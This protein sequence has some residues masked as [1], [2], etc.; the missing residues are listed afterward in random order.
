MHALRECQRFTTLRALCK[1]LIEPLLQAA[2]DW[3]LD[4]PAPASAPSAGAAVAPAGYHRSALSGQICSPPVLALECVL[5]GYQ[6]SSELA[7]GALPALMHVLDAAGEHDKRAVVHVLR[8]LMLVFSG[9]DAVWEVVRA[10]LQDFAPTPRTQLMHSLYQAQWLVGAPLPVPA[11][12]AS[13]TP[14][15]SAAP[16]AQVQ[17]PAPAA[18]AAAP[19]AAAGP[20]P[21]PAA[22]AAAGSEV[23]PPLPNPTVG[24]V[25]GEWAS[26]AAGGHIKWALSAGSHSITGAGAAAAGG[27]AGSVVRGS[28]RRVHGKARAGVPSA[29]SRD[30]EPLSHSSCLAGLKRGGTCVVLWEGMQYVMANIVDSRQDELLLKA[31]LK[32]NAERWV[33][34]HSTSYHILSHHITSHHTIPHFHTAHPCLRCVGC[35]VC[36]LRRSS[37]MQC[38]TTLQCPAPKL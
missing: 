36:A 6:H 11:A 1:E 37:V 19:Q 22:A 20:A 21:T 4:P 27:G 5:L 30:L 10:Q 25:E 16:S 15:S 33:H 14:S 2:S 28:Y 17:A 26:K 18:G 3:M 9:Y 35:V 38:C 8:C 34:P 12:A 31:P 23:M 29:V 32:G 7:L 24:W 13:A